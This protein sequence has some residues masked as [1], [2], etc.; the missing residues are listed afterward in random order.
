MKPKEAARIFDTLEMDVLLSV[1]GKMNERKMSPILA[2][3]DPD[4]AREVTIKLAEQRKLPS[5]PEDSKKTTPTKAAP[6]APSEKTAPAPAAPS[7]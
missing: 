3:M 4:K 1:I 2:S 7:P 6:A 5:L